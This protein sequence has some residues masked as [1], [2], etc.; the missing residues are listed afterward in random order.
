M[1][2]RAAKLEASMQVSIDMPYALNMDSD[3][4]NNHTHRVIT[5]TSRSPTLGLKID[6]CPKR[7]LPILKTCM[8]GQPAAKIP[9]WRKDLKNDVAYIDAKSRDKSNV[10]QLLQKSW[11][12]WHQ[13]E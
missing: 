9:N 3:P 13:M 5:M 1:N 8:P 7:H 6:T 11:L 10:E 12:N 2:A 4:Y